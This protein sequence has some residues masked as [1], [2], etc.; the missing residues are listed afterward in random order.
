MWVNFT[1]SAYSASIPS[2]P[3]YLTVMNAKA[4]GRDIILAIIDN[5]RE[6]KE[7]LLYSTVVPS[8]YD[9]YLHPEDHERLAGIFPQIREQAK[10]AL[11]EGLNELNGAKRSFLPGLKTRRPKH[12]PAEGDWYIKFHKDEDEELAPGDILVDSQLTLPP[13][14]EFGAGG[15]TQRTVTVRSGGETKKLRTYQENQ[16][17]APAALAKLAY[18]DKKGE[19]REFLMTTPEIAIGRG[20]RAE[21]CDL[22]LDGPV[23]I[24]RQ[25]F[26][27]RQDEKTREFFLQDVSRF[28]TTVNGKD[29]APKEWVQIPAKAKIGLAGKMVIEFESL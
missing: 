27:L 14:K 23:D 7:P 13:Q 6:S 2:S 10:R 3:W 19:R 4:V 8:L 24:S 17:T 9:V 11:S 15:K 29:V 25:H 28:G 18:Q 22:E 20:G 1:L 16:P 26:Y 21:Y 12:E 5:M